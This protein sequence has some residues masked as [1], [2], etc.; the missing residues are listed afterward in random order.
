MN[1][2]KKTLQRLGNAPSAVP[3]T[4]DECDLLVRDASEGDIY[5]ALTTGDLTASQGV[6]LTI[7][8]QALRAER[9]AKERGQR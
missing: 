9:R 7:R 5:V 3:I 6:R 8:A 4:D 1:A 2:V